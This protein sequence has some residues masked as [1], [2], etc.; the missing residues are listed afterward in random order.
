MKH[1]AHCFDLQTSV[2][3]DVHAF[4][5]QR[6]A[7]FGQVDPDLMLASGFEA[8]FDQRGA[9]QSADRPDVRNRS[10][11]LEWS[12]A[13]RTAEVSMRAA[14]SVAAIQKEKRFDPLRGDDTVRNGE[15]D[16][17]DGV[18][19]ELRCQRALRMGSPRKHHQA[20]RILVESMHHAECGV[21]A[22][23]VHLPQ[24]RT[25]VVYGRF[26]VLRLVGDAEEPRWLVD[27]D[28]VAVAKHDGARGKRTRAE[29]RCPLVDGNH[30]ARRD[31][32]R[33]VEAALAIYADAPLGA[34]ST[35]QRPGDARLLANDRGDGGIG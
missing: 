20:A 7:E 8:A 19:A 17:I 4:A 9:D 31:P 14:Q 25:R 16:A 11:C 22:P 29:L 21:N 32:R 12:G 33:R 18:L 30:D 1:R 35:R 15:I 2:V 27:D 23:L 24:Q 34:P 13:L 6:M 5:D 3:A 28:D 26:P 10:S